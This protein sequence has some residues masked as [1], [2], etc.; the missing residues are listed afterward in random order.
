M[1]S[2]RAARLF[3]GSKEERKGKPKDIWRR[4]T[5]L[6]RADWL[7]KSCLSS[8]IKVTHTRGQAMTH[9]DVGPQRNKKQLKKFGTS[10]DKPVTSG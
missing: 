1:F 9:G 2:Q 7:E 4:M 3:K 10:G 6:Y 5:G 8:P